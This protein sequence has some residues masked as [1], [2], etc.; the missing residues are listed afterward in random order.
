VNGQIFLHAGELTNGVIPLC[1]LPLD[2]GQ[3]IVRCPTFSSIRYKKDVLDFR[4]GLNLLSR[5][6]P[7]SFRSK[8][9]VRADLGLI[10]EEV[11]RAE[12]L[13]VTRDEQG[14]VQGVKYDRIGV[15]LVSA[16]KEQQEQIREQQNQLRQQRAE[17][18]A[19]KGLVCRNRPKA[20]ICKPTP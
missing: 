15:V 7:V 5:R 9:S 4:P 18:E 3:L 11:E 17:I 20:Q 8:E 13:L 6:R 2:G 19:L 12:P 10:A 1:G 16:V 14:A